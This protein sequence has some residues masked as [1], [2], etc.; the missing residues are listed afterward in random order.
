MKRPANY[1]SW[2]GLLEPEAEPPLSPN[3][4]SCPGGK[5]CASGA[6]ESHVTVGNDPTPHES[7]SRSMGDHTGPPPSAIQSSPL[8]E[9]DAISWPECLAMLKERW[10]SPAEEVSIWVH[11]GRIHTYCYVSDGG[12]HAE[13]PVG[14]PDDESTSAYDLLVPYKYDRREIENFTP[15]DADCEEPVRKFSEVA[16]QSHWAA[17]F[18]PSGRYLSFEQAVSFLCA[19]SGLRPLDA[20]EVGAFLRHEIKKARV[21]PRDAFGNGIEDP[22]RVKTAWFSEAAILMLA[23]E[24]WTAEFDRWDAA[25]R[26]L[27][28]ISKKPPRSSH[29]AGDRSKGAPSRVDSLSKYRNMQNLAWSEVKM[30][31]LPENRVEITARRERVIVLLSALGLANKKTGGPNGEGVILSL[32]SKSYRFDRSINKLQQRVY[33][34]RKLL[35]NAFGIQADPFSTDWVPHFGLENRVKARDD[36]A[37]RDAEFR[38]TKRFDETRHAYD[39]TE[40]PYDPPKDDDPAAPWLT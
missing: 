16:G 35:K 25:S 40:Y 33:C 27:R 19:L 34:L 11:G 1:V 29:V 23:R 10:A 28:L 2:Q 24:H 31:L 21:M 18:N 37:K 26:W 30:R 20:D 14:L 8:P 9:A 12:F 17:F 15:T 32:M 5:N 13:V 22:Q 4:E 7:S 6:I 38:G 36:R 39:E 3:A